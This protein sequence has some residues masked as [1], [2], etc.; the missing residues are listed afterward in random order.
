[1]LL[2]WLSLGKKD[3]RERE[4]EKKIYIYVKLGR[5][6]DGVFKIQRV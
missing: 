3:E 6:N 2:G 1:M 4:R 5:E